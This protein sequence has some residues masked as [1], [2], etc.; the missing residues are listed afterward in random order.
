M[1]AKRSLEA[2]DQ[3]APTADIGPPKRITKKVRAAIDAMVS[4]EC[5]GI[6]D[7]AA[8]VGSPAKACP[9]P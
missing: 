3:P 4:G 2:L 9:A 7:A 1:P 6:C 5:K 8:K